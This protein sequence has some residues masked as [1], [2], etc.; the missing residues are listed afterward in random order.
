MIALTTIAVA[1][2]A[3]TP[4]PKQ[5]VYQFQIIDSSGVA[6]PVVRDLEKEPAVVK[7]SSGDQNFS[8]K[9]IPDSQASD[10]TIVTK[11]EILRSTT[12][13]TNEDG[14]AITSTREFQ[15]ISTVDAKPGEQT[16]FLIKGDTMKRIQPKK[17]KAHGGEVLITVSAS[18]PQ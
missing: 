15:A 5:Y 4:A 12:T 1:A 11:I 8:I 10:S 3:Q 16:V 6:R 18:V 17:L 13:R 7:F 14:S 9:V 2:L